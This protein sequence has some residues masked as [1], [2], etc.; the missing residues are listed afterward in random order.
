MK[1]VS[2]EAYPVKL[3]LQEPFTIAYSTIDHTINYFLRVETNSNI[4]GYG[5]SA[6]DEEVT[7]ENSV[8]LKR[9]LNDVAIPL[10]LNKD[11]L[12]YQS[13][14]KEVKKNLPNSPTALAAVDMAL[15]DIA[16]KK[17]NL[18]LYRFL[19]GGLRTKIKTS[20]TIGI[21]PIEESVKK[22]IEWKQRGYLALKVK[23]GVS[24]QEDIEKLKKI[25]EAVGSEIDI[26][27]DANQGYSEK[28]A[29]LVIK[30]LAKVGSKFIEQPCD[31][32][33]LEVFSRLKGELPI[34][35][36]ESVLSGSDVLKLISRGGSDLYNIKLAKSGGILG[37]LEFDAISE[38]SGSATMVGCMDEAALGISGALHF[39]LARDNVKFADLDGHVEFIDDPSYNAVI[40]KDGY[41]YPK[42]QIGLGFKD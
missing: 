11:P 17:A 15:F 41:I 35:A 34:M 10:L 8:T 18:P 21:L 25:R 42:D 12:S 26:Y 2:V 39:T 9:D 6:Y 1:I 32:N 19:G 24:Y 23:G 20:I 30:T 28:E 40:I 3:T 16:S 38:A 4:V 5:C 13:L 7:G 29:S 37:A 36:D 31:K 22:A 14:I 33:D 27:F